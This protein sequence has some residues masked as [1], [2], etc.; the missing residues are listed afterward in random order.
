MV[1]MATHRSALSNISAQACIAPVHPSCYL[2]YAGHPLE[3]LLSKNK[4]H[5]K[6]IIYAPKRA[7]MTAAHTSHTA[8]SLK[9]DENL[10][11]MSQTR[12]KKNG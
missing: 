10:L 4:L 9:T 1:L 2:Q 6:H 5:N 12:K 8:T 7:Y 3:N 11:N